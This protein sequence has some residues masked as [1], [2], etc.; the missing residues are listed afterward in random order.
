MSQACSEMPA[1]ERGTSPNAR[2]RTASASESDADGDDEAGEVRRAAAEADG[3]TA[4]NVASTAR[5]QDDCAERSPGASGMCCVE[6]EREEA[7]E[8]REDALREVDDPGRP[9]DEDERH[10]DDPEHGSGRDAR[11]RSAAGTSSRRGRSRRRG[12]R[13]RTS[14]RSRSSALGPSTREATRLEHVRPLAERE[15][16]PRVLVDEQDARR[17]PPRSGARGTP[18]AARRRAGRGRARA[19]RSRAPRGSAI[20][21]RPIATICC[22]P[23]DVRP[24]GRSRSSRSFGRSV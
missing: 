13:C 10:P 5:E 24:A 16:Q 21:A 9:I 22:S 18:P 7:A 12:R 20:S 4:V 3:D 2:S 19:R 23:P 15:R 6:L 17:P 8:D 1:Y 14:G 11:R